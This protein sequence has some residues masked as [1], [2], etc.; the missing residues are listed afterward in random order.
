MKIE[1]ILLSRK[2]AD[3]LFSFYDGGFN[4]I[5]G[6]RPEVNGRFIFCD[7]YFR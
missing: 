2:T 7:F 1:P 5:C 3:S 4:M 6:G